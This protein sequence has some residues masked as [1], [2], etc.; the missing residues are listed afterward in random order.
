M[1]EF[2][3]LPK[4]EYEQIMRL[5]LLLKDLL[6]LGRFGRT[7]NLTTSSIHKPHKVSNIILL[8]NNMYAEIIKP[9]MS[10]IKILVT[11]RFEK[12]IVCS[13]INIRWAIS[14]FYFRNSRT[15]LCLSMVVTTWVSSPS[16]FSEGLMCHLAYPQ[17]TN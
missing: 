9:Q 3:Y 12:D 7:G 15:D 6:I 1:E 10:H 16:L 17:I 11:Q 2:L 8:D 5:F 14:I 13:L 4:Q